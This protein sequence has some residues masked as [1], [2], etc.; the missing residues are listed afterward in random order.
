MKNRTPF[1]S[2]AAGTGR[3][4]AAFKELAEQMQSVILRSSASL[5]SRRIQNLWKK[6]H[7]LQALVMAERKA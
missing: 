3:L 4:D 2:C 5:D 6:F 7:E 1:D